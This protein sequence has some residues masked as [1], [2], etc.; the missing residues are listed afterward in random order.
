MLV[1]HLGANLI[2][3]LLEVNLDLLTLSN[4]CILDFNVFQVKVLILVLVLIANH[5]KLL[6]RQISALVSLR[7]LSI[8][9]LV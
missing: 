1:N 6:S 9:S 7:V 5:L 8:M 4:L 3:V 2:N